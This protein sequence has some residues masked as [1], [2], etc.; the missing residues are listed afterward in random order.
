VARCLY[1][2][3]LTLLPGEKPYQKH[4]FNQETR[5]TVIALANTF[6]ETAFTFFGFDKVYLVNP[7][8][9]GQH[10]SNAHHLNAKVVI[11]AELPA[12]IIKVMVLEP[13]PIALDQVRDYSKKIMAEMA[14]SLPYAYE[15]NPPGINKA[16]SLMALLKEM[17][18]DHIPIYAAG[19]A[20]N[21]LALFELAQTSFAP[22]D[23]H[24]K[25]LQRADHHISRAESGLLAPIMEHI[26]PP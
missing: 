26:A 9:F 14:T 12:E 4:V 16:A 24:P 5:Q 11:A 18:M 15:I 17:H 19:D 1:E 2:W 8:S 25:V 22:T 20:E 3:R 21:D 23:A 6:S 7:N 10:I 13:D